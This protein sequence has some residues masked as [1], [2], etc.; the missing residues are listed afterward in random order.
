MKDVYYSVIMY[1]KQFSNL[2]WKFLYFFIKLCFLFRTSGLLE[3]TLYKGIDYFENLWTSAN[4]WRTLTKHL[5]V[6]ICRGY[7]IFEFQLWL[8]FMGG[9]C[10]SKK[11]ADRRIDPNALI[12]VIIS[13]IKNRKYSAIVSKTQHRILIYTFCFSRYFA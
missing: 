12:F 13:Q 11:I 9:G 4:R 1:S 5:N 3:V 10:C 6:E 2:A 7:P 8:S